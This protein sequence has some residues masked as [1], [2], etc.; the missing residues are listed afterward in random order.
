MKKLIFSQEHTTL[1]I[2]KLEK[3]K[4]SLSVTRNPNIKPIVEDY[5]KTLEEVKQAA[6]GGNVIFIIESD[7]T[8]MGV[9]NIETNTT[10]RN[11]DKMIAHLLYVAVP[12]PEFRVSPDA[13]VSVYSEG[14]VVFNLLDETVKG[15]L[16]LLEPEV[17]KKVV[18]VTPEDVLKEW[19][20]ELEGD[21]EIFDPVSPAKAEREPQVFIVKDKAILNLI[22][23]YLS[24]AGLPNLFINNIVPVDVARSLSKTEKAAFLLRVPYSSVASTHNFVNVGEQNKVLGIKTVGTVSMQVT[25]ADNTTETVKL[26]SEDYDAFLDW[27]EDVEIK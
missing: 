12:N 14:K 11:V 13:R 23:N 16:D 10:T 9:T 4:G 3:F 19:K 18:V 21:A 15:Y 22:N 6:K 25:F 20:K 26:K 27:L 1:M 8:L 5:I 7:K 17:E 2:E 24:E